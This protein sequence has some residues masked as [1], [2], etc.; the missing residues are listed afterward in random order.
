MAK[1]GSQHSS[2]Q[3]R[4][5]QMRAEQQRKDKR[6]RYIIWGVLA[7][8]VVAAAV[9]IAVV[10]TKTS[11]QKAE[12]KDANPIVIGKSVGQAN[13]GKPVVEEYLSYSCSHCIEVAEPLQKPLIEKAQAGEITLKLHPV[14][15]AQMAY[16]SVATS[17]AVLTAKDD[18]QHFLPL[19]Y[20]LDS[21]FKTQMDAKD[22]SVVQ[23]KS[24]SLAKVKELA[25]QAGVNSDVV[26][27]ISEASGDAYLSAAY[28]NWKARK[29]EGLSKDDGLGTPM[30]V[31]NDKYVRITG[32]PAQAAQDLKTIM[33]AAA[34]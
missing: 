11:A 20:A 33:D 29:I 3:Q 24:K 25:N 12:L 15:T 31:V 8:V 17:A 19:H 23:D 1:Q 34:K 9:I 26:N 7:L 10:A 18:P 5:A 28:D 2:I 4:A 22:G 21:F 30:F 14:P 6:V 13:D 16:T 32:A 27:R